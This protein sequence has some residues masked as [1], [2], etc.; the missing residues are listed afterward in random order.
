MS[1]P[2]ANMSVW[3]GNSGVCI[4]IAGRASF[5]TS[6][7]LK[8]LVNGLAARG[9][10]HFLLDLSECVLMDSTFLG[11]LAGYGVRYKNRNGAVEPCI[12][13]SHPSPRISDLLANLGVSDLFPVVVSPGVAPEKL[14]PVAPAQDVDKKEISK[15]CLEAH[16]AALTLW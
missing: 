8:S 3:V 15:I 6:V 11:V 4:K 2:S 14:Q 7:D 13:L 12:A 16:L 5:T 9:Q 10:R 1:A